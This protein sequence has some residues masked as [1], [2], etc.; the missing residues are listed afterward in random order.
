MENTRSH[1]ALLQGP[2]PLLECDASMR[3]ATSCSVGHQATGH[4]PQGSGRGPE[5]CLSGRAG[6]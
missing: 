4:P 5:G 3:A 1:A 2:A 6:G